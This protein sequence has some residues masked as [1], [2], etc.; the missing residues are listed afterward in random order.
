MTL[1]PLNMSERRTFDLL[2]PITSSVV[3]VSLKVSIKRRSSSSCANYKKQHKIM[4]KKLVNWQ[5]N[6]KYKRM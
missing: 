1:K 6:Q 3:E 4:N 2:S 5:V